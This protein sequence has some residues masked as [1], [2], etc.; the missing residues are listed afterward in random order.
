MGNF[1]ELSEINGAEIQQDKDR[2]FERIL[3]LSLKVKDP[4]L[5][6]H[7]SEKKAQI[8]SF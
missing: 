5:F 3:Q 4:T 2:M 6:S 8:Y 1:P 7:K